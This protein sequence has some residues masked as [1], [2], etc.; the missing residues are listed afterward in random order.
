MPY[1]AVTYRVKPGHEEEIAA[2]FAGFRP[3]AD[4]SMVREDGSAAGRLLG[5]AVFIKDDVV[6][7]VVHY[8]GDFAAVGQKVGAQRGTHLIE[9]QLAPFLAAGRE[10]RSEEGFATYFRDAT[11]R[12]ISHLPPLPT[13]TP[14]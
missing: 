12:C 1:A 4:P 6:V 8:E 2:I 5:T 11:M 3:M 10:T 14:R 13:A 9:E 7:R